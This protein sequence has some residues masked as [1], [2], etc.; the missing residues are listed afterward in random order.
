MCEPAP[1]APC[2]A[3]AVPPGHVARRRPAFATRAGG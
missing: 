2:R 1:L 3:T